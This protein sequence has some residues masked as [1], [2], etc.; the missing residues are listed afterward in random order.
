MPPPVDSGNKTAAAATS[1]AKKPLP[2]PPGSYCRHYCCYGT[3]SYGN[4]CRYLHEMPY[5]VNGLHGVGLMELPAWWHTS[6]DRLRMGMPHMGHV[7]YPMVPVAPWD[8]PAARAF[9]PPGPQNPKWKKIKAATKGHK[10]K[11]S[12]KAKV[13]RPEEK[14]P[15]KAAKAKQPEAEV[16]Q[17]DSPKVQASMRKGAET[18][19]TSTTSALAQKEALVDGKLVD[20]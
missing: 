11:G 19:T 16:D 18:K 3:C 20:V 15:D 7:N 10:T 6:P 8:M 2:P 1:S 4:G 9:S 13:A 5:T 14:A 17:G 12:E